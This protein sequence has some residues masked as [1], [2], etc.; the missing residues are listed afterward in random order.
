[1]QDR[2]PTQA[3]P[4]QTRKSPTRPAESGPR[5]PVPAESGNGGSLFPGRLGKRAR[6]SPPRPLRHAEHAHLLSDIEKLTLPV[7]RRRPNRESGERKLGIS[8][9]GPA[10]AAGRA[11]GGPRGSGVP[12]PGPGDLA[13]A[14]HSIVPWKNSRQTT[15]GTEP[16]AAAADSEVAC[17][18]YIAWGGGGGLGGCLPVLSVD[19]L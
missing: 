10:P 6:G 17:Q 19:R 3:G 18:C 16:G 7:S 11:A 8:G 4:A 9:S 15:W 5:F 1:L 14:N 12:C 13:P 2:P